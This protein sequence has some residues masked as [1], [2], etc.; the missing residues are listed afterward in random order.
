MFRSRRRQRKPVKDSQT[1]KTVFSYHNVPRSAEAQPNMEARNARGQGR[2]SRFDWRQLPSLVAVAAIIVSGGYVLTLS[3]T[4]KIRAQNGAQQE[5][6][7]SPAVYEAKAQEVLRSSLG[8]RLKMTINTHAI[9]KAMETEFP[10]L[11]TVAVILP[12]MGNQPTIELKAAAPSL[13]V[14]ADHGDYILNQSGVAVMRVSDAADVKSLDL[15]SVQDESTLDITP[16]KGVLTP[17]ETTF[18]MIVG[19]QLR[20]KKLE[21]ESIV[22]PAIPNEVRVKL[23]RQPYYI[24]FH[25]QADPYE[26]IGTFLAT[27]KYLEEEKI[28]PSRYIDVRAEG[29]AYYR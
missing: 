11:E 5:L 10:E 2:Q 21:I 6:M 18:I 23:A 20:Q 16:G 7:R 12:L 15:L 13:L 8:N 25:M 1:A 28:I 27:K 14:K 17:A 3:T 9:E 26:S 4:P 29:R 24:R 19:A 22:L